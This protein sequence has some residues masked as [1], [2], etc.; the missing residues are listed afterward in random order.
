VGG[1]RTGRAVTVTQISGG[2]ADPDHGHSSGRLVKAELAVACRSLEGSGYA[3]KRYSKTGDDIDQ[4]LCLNPLSIKV[5]YVQGELTEAKQYPEDSFGM[6][7][8]I[9]LPTEQLL[10]LKLR[11]PSFASQGNSMILPAF[12]MQRFGGL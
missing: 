7:D 9:T 11:A 4:V 12:H 6:S 1:D 8:G 3:Y 5:K 2:Y 10:H